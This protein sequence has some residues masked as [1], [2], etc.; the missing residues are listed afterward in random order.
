MGHWY[1]ALA[2]AAPQGLRPP[3]GHNGD[4]TGHDGTPIE[5]AK[6][7]CEPVWLELST[8][9][10]AETAKRRDQD[11]N[12]CQYPSQNVSH[13]VRSQWISQPIRRVRGSDRD[14]EKGHYSHF[15][16][17]APSFIARAERSTTEHT[18][19]TDKS[20]QLNDIA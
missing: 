11:K 9:E 8:G 14:G 20:K 6:R 19:D 7:I 2:R 4:D 1:L 15:I 10:V 18:E 12:P 13:G 5:P 16:R 3:N 17:D